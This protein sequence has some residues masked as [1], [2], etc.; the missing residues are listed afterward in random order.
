ML[1]GAGTVPSP[2][3]ARAAFEAGAQFARA[4]E[5]SGEVVDC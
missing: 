3:Q 4:P 1:V 2:E 5:T